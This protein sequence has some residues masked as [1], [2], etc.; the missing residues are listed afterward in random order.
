MTE[1]WMNTLLINPPSSV[2]LQEHTGFRFLS[3]NGLGLHMQLT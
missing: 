2:R 1:A 3:S